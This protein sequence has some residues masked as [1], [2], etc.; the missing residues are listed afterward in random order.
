MDFHCIG[1]H[2]TNRAFDFRDGLALHAQ[3]NQ[4]GADLGLCGLTGHDDVHR[5]LGFLGGQVG[6]VYG[7]G[8]KWF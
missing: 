1:T 5:L 4:V 3:S 2:R 8:N 7:F 6:T